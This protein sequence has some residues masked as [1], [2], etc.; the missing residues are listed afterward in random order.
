MKY[1]GAVFF[2]YDGT[3]VDEKT[4]IFSPTKDTINS[5]EK[6]QKNGFL[7]C[8]ATGR[9]LCYGPDPSVK[10]DGY[11]TANG[12]Y[13]CVDG[14]VI[15]NITFSNELYLK[16]LNEFSKRNLQFS[17]ENQD[18]FYANDIN[19]DKFLKMLSTFSIGTENLRPLEEL[20]ITTIN[21]A[22]V[23][24]D[25]EEQLEELRELFC[26]DLVFDRH[27]DYF[28]GDVTLKCINKGVGALKVIEALKIPYELTFAFGDGTND[29][30]MIKSVRHG[31]AMGIS[32]DETRA[33]AEYV[34]DTVIN[35]GVSKA[36]KYYDII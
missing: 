35:E 13:A 29:L 18:L 4:S 3:L 20:D 19:G 8:L 6:L 9:S 11:I 10:F 16:V 36:L 21:K 23:T 30:E 22:L 26:D 5:I 32:A 24:F 7:V 1:T 33:A 12:A 2:D 17:F 28:S 31:V 25:S 34:T 27:R 14:E 15:S